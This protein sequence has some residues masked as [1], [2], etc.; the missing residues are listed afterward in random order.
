MVA[1]SRGERSGCPNADVGMPAVRTTEAQL[2]AARRCEVPSVKIA[3]GIVGSTG[4]GG[5]GTMGLAVA[6]AA[7]GHTVPVG[8]WLVSAALVTAAALISS[9]SLMLDYWLKK[10]AVQAQ[11]KRFA[12]AAE[13]QKERLTL[14]RIVLEKAAG[15]PGN[16]A[17]YRQ[18]II[19]DA[20]HLSVEQNGARLADRTHERLYGPVPQAVGVS[21]DSEDDRCQPAPAKRI[22]VCGSQEVPPCDALD[23]P[24][25]YAGRRRDTV[26]VTGSIPVSPTSIGAGQGLVSRPGVPFGRRSALQ[27]AHH[28]WRRLIGG[29]GSGAS[30]SIMLVSAR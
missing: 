16:A 2:S 27:F 30:P 6:R 21:P 20:L 13:L 24:R 11:E 26:E 29:G 22:E 19:A 25:S 1:A 8:L 3:A 9:L 14:H 17:S 18:L 15:E 10:L 7:S 28:R 5:L 4:A 23:L 12:A